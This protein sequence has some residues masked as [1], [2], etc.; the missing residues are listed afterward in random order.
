MFGYPSLPAGLVE[1]ARQRGPRQFFSG[2]ASGT[3]G[4]FQVGPGL[5]QLLLVLLVLLSAT[6]AARLLL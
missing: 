6:A 4:L 2:L 5:Q 3:Q 1:S